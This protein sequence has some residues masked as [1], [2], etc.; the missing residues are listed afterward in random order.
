M[1]APLSQGKPRGCD[2]PRCYL[3]RSNVRVHLV[4]CVEDIGLISVDYL[5]P[6]VDAIVSSLLGHFLLIAASFLEVW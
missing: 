1:D 4:G 6:I 5:K 2:S 3:W